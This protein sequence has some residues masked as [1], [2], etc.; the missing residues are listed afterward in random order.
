M[1]D[2]CPMTNDEADSGAGF[3]HPSWVIRH[4]SFRAKRGY[5]LLELIIALTIFAIAVVGLAK[6]LNTTLE[7]G[8]IM[9]RDYAVRI[10]LQSFVEEVKRK[11]ISDMAT[12]ATDERLGATYTSTV[13]SLS[14]TVPRSGAQLSDC[15][16]L[17]ATAV[18]TVGSEQRDETIELW[19]YQT[20]AEQEK[21]RTR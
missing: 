2:P 12:T 9:N 16:R 19:L 14:L 20:Q 17:T 6:S 8:N 18:Y 21:R 4:G 11:A 1:S 10:G 15:Y 3:R 13:D 7:V 5:I